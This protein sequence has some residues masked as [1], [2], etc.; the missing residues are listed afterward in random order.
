MADVGAEPNLNVHGFAPLTLL[1]SNCRV[2]SAG[3]I[4]VGVAA[5]SVSDV[6]VIVSA[7]R[8]SLLERF[9]MNCV[10]RLPCEDR[11]PRCIAQN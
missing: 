10:T 5:D 9:N 8:Y 11:Q 4:W 3:R 6:V 2:V 7:K 1:S